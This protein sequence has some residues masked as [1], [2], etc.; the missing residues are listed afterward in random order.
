MQH[1]NWAAC[2]PAHD[3][4]HPSLGIKLT[5]EGKILLHCFSDECA[6]DDIVSAIGMDLSDLFPPKDN[7]PKYEQSRRTYFD[8]G[9][10]LK[11]LAYESAVLAL[12][13]QDIVN[14]MPLTQEDADR[15][16]LASNRIYTAKTYCFTFKELIS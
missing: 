15:I 1:N 7:Q 8:P 13:A 4:T 2:C 14:K 16:E 10:V 11:C 9:T 12:A 3:D 6:I 5:D